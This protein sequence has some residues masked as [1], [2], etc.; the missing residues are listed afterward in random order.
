M[1]I[2]LNGWFLD[3]GDGSNILNYLKEGGI[4]TSGYTTVDD[5]VY[6]L[7][8]DTVTADFI[9]ADKDKTRLAISCIFLN[10]VYSFPSLPASL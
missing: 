1:R 4:D 8:C 5:P 10:R 9:A 3:N 7:Q 6:F 2:A